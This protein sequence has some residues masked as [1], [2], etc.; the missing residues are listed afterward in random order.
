VVKSFK[1][2]VS[3]AR[4]N[5]VGKPYVDNKKYK[6]GDIFHPTRDY[7]HIGTHQGHDYYASGESVK[8]TGKYHK[9]NGEKAVIDHNSKSRS[10]HL[11]IKAHN[12]KTGHVEKTVDGELH[13]GMLH[14][15]NLYG[16]KDSSHKAHHFYHNIVKH[17]VKGTVHHNQSDGAQKVMQNL[18]KKPGTTV[19]GV[20]QVRHKTKAYNLGK[21]FDTSETHEKQDY[22]QDPHGKSK[23]LNRTIVAV[24][25][26]SFKKK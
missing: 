24:H 15:D 8:G 14:V 3:E 12:P 18:A 17:Y 22:D 19:H 16:R 13:K 25:K 7:K 11:S 26:D 21:D 6:S 10:N 20:D 23:V 5:T 4:S 1:Q 2:F 9:T